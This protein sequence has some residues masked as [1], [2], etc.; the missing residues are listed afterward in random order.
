MRSCGGPHDGG[1]DEDLADAGQERN[2][3][4]VVAGLLRQSRQPPPGRLTDVQLRSARLTCGNVMDQVN[5]EV[6]KDIAAG[7]SHVQESGLR[8]RSDL[9]KGVHTC[10]L[11]L[12]PT[13]PCHDAG[14]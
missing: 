9:F 11:Q 10:T 5:G 8:P 1:R 7:Q 3:A 4:G 2:S 6:M 14:P 13:N 12:T